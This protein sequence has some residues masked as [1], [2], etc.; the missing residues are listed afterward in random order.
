M[1]IEELDRMFPPVAEQR[2]VL[3]S[4]APANELHYIDRYP[5]RL[6]LGEVASA[7]ELLGRQP[8]HLERLRMMLK[9]LER[10]LTPHP[11]VVEPPCPGCGYR[12]R[13]S[14]SC[15]EVK[16]TPGLT[17]EDLSLRDG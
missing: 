17:R 10:L 16:D 9:E 1:T 11:V 2:T 12:H 14:P 3:V 5:T 8:I 13:H 6:T 7:R 15:R 4:T